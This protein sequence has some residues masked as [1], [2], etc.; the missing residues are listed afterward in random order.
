MRSHL[1]TAVLHAAD[2][3]DRGLLNGSWNV[4]IWCKHVVP[5][6]GLPDDKYYAG[7]QTASTFPY[8]N[9]GTLFAQCIVIASLACRTSSFLPSRQTVFPKWSYIILLRATQVGGG[10]KEHA[11]DRSGRPRAM[12]ETP[13]WMLY[14]RYDS[15]P[16]G[17]LGK[18]DCVNNPKCISKWAECRV[19]LKGRHVAG[20]WLDLWRAPIA[21]LWMSWQPPQNIDNFG[22]GDRQHL[23]TLCHRAE[24]LS[25]L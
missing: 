22:R 19:V 6:R 24:R 9:T 5:S 13:R 15:W 20:S 16:C 14:S 3:F 23:F 21:R 17:I 1:V 4:K 11:S 10:A 18:V 7:D 2:D 12:N 8:R 25:W